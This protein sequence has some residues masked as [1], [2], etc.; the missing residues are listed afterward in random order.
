GNIAAGLI[1]P[2]H[3]NFLHISN[4]AVSLS[5]HLGIHWSCTFNFLQ[6]LL[7]IHN[8][9][10]WLKQPSFWPISAFKICYWPF[11]TVKERV[12][13]CHPGW[14]ASGMIT[15]HCSLNLLGSSNPP[16][17]ASQ[18]AGTTGVCHHTW[19]LFPLFCKDGASL[20]CPDWSQ[21]PVLKRSSQISLPI[22]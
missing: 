18:V 5:Y 2:D 17:L 6:E 20:C 8:L 22:C 14:S 4:K 13:L 7:C 16:I 10:I 9:A 21:T 19:L 3:Y 1:Y 15:A 12:L 11:I